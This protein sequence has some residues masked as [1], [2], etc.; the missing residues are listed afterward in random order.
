M[1]L[2]MRTFTNFQKRSN[3]RLILCILLSLFCSAFYEIKAQ[4]P[5]E[6]QVYTGWSGIYKTDLS[7]NVSPDDY[8]R[9]PFRLCGMIGAQIH[10]SEGNWHLN[11]GLNY[12]RVNAFFEYGYEGENYFRVTD[13]YQL[14]Y[15][16]SSM[17]LSFD[18]K[19]LRLTGGMQFDFPF[20]HRRL[21]RIETVIN[22]KAYRMY[23]KDGYAK[24]S[25]ALGP[26]LELSYII[27]PK[28]QVKIR[29]VHGVN[30]VLR[31]SKTYTNQLYLGASYLINHK[32]MSYNSNL[33]D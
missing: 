6:L 26:Y 24:K 13:W 19:A 28:W 27:D 23:Y 16:S 31:R 5:I 15:L 20:L 9:T 18:H 25:V 12:S 21:T 33:S 17:G 29:G 14:N 2:N 30:S 3:H 4:E 7:E 11:M 1:N 10:F 22:R 32:R 8:T